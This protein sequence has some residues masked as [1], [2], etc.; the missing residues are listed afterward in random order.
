MTKLQK[1]AVLP[2]ASAYYECEEKLWRVIVEP[3]RYFNCWDG[4]RKNFLHENGTPI[5]SD[6]FEF[7]S[8]FHCGWARVGKRNKAGEHIYNFINRDGL[9]FSEIWYWGAEDFQGYVALVTIG[10]SAN[11]C[12]QK[13]IGATGTI[14]EWFNKR[15][16]RIFQYPAEEIMAVSTERPEKH[17]TE[18]DELGNWGYVAMDGTILVEPQFA[19]ARS[20][21]RGYAEVCRENG[22]GDYL[23]GLIDR[24]GIEIIP[25]RYTEIQRLQDQE[26]PWYRVEVDHEKWGII[27]DKNEW[28]VKPLW[29]DLG[30]WMEADGYI[31]V[32]L[33]D[34]WKD[35]STENLKG[36]LRISD[37]KL[38]VPMEYTD[39]EFVREGLYRVCRAYN[40]HSSSPQWHYE[41]WLVDGENKNVIQG[42]QFQFISIFQGL[43]YEVR[44]LAT[45]KDGLMDE[46][47]NMIVECKYH[48]LNDVHRA[49]EWFVH[50][51]GNQVTVFDFHEQVVL[52]PKY[53]WARFRERD[54]IEVAFGGRDENGKFEWQQGKYGLLDFELKEVLPPIYSH[55]T[56]VDDLVLAQDGL[57][58]SVFRIV[59]HEVS[60]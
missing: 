46:K 55:I 51:D 14:L 49:K 17:V 50:D 7:L 22:K 56:F 5:S 10:E 13:L 59:D 12:S 4:G 29:G 40:E 52:P 38:L 1:V 20:F 54:F 24:N 45:G 44:D 53:N 19:A 3:N 31:E 37:E 2:V 36:L 42:K 47:G 15:G 58:C 35:T 30:Y 27:S 16:Y 23:W 9:F 34:F 11:S 43:P 8:E 39:V 18:Y 6:Y 33:R 21:E 57:Q 48:R 32:G 25:C 26:N 41:Y 60:D 28:I